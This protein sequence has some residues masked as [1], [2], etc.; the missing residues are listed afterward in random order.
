MEQHVSDAKAKGAKILLGGKRSA[1]GKT[2]Y[3]ATVMTEVTTDMKCAKEEI[4][5]P[6]A[7]I[8]K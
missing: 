8:M 5:G 1:L 3:E 2:F 7:A 6:V 4:F